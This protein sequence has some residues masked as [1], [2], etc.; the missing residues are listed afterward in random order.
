[1]KILS[2]TTTRISIATVF[3]SAALAGCGGGSSGLSAQ[4]HR[5]F[6]GGCTRTGSASG[7]C[8]CMFTRLT[9]KQ[10]FNSEAKLKAV[11]ADTGRYISVIRQDAIACKA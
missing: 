5:D 6:V 9:V 2:R 4:A 11:L 8:E 1:M 3:V 7:M 10:G